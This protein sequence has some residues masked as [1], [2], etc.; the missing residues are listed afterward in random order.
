MRRI[1]R[2][3]V[4]IFTALIMTTATA[5]AKKQEGQDMANYMEDI[6]DIELTGG[7]IHRSFCMHAI[8]MGDMKANRFGVRVYRNRQPVTLNGSCKGFFIR[9]SG[10]T[11]AINNGVVDGNTAY[12]VLPEECYE[13]EGRFSLAIKVTTSGETVTM[14][15]VDG[16]VSRT[17][18]NMP[19]PEINR[20]VEELIELIAEAEATIPQTYSDVNKAIRI[21]ANGIQNESLSF[22]QG[23]ISGDTGAFYDGSTQ[24]RTGFIYVGKGNGI[25]LTMSNGYRGHVRWYS[26]AS[27]ALFVSAQNEVSGY[28]TA[29]ADFL[30]F[31][32]TAPDWGDIVPSEGSNAAMKVVSSSEMRYGASKVAYILSSSEIKLETHTWVLS[33]PTSS[34]CRIITSFGERFDVRLGDVTLS[35]SCVVYFKRD[36]KTIVKKDYTETIDDTELFLLGVI[37]GIQL[38]NLNILSMF[39]V[40]GVSSVGNTPE[41]MHLYGYRYGIA[42]VAVLGDS[43]STYSGYSEGAYYPTG[44]VDTVE[45]TW[46]A[47][48]T[49]G[50]RLDIDEASV[51]AISRTA[52]IDQNDESLP[53]AYDSTRIARLGAGG[54][55]SYIF[56]NMG[57][58]DPYLNNIGEMTYESDINA[59]NDLPNSTTK[60]IALTIR[61]LQQAYSDA[62]IVML[63]PKPVAIDTVKS[64]SPQY[65]AEN[66]E[67]VAERIK[68]LGELYG[69][70]KVIDLRKC[71]INQSNVA[72]YCGDS[73]IHPNAL[74]MRRMA[75]YILHE[76]IQ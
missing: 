71:D 6:V 15:I 63:I 68:Q 54:Y 45:E 39:N 24:I 60:G 23:A 33:L 10:D 73:S 55:P 40:N 13:V 7:S 3:A 58:N 64:I 67:K 49:R 19:T 72:S 47:R 5:G 21:T 22:V 65:T 25:K 41:Y 1:I 61:K 53:P 12:V 66:V 51:S 44:D 50:M 4:I 14:R 18:T 26:G 27:Q 32:V 56:V 9:S 11:I 42:R 34:Y 46:W 16:V 20:T 43:I 2:K 75:D 37:N 17:S 35:Q 30:A 52:F 57:T 70:Y 29:P 28:I 8:G 59:L 69:V 76:L 31:C 62:R 36:T 38:I 48:V 74:G